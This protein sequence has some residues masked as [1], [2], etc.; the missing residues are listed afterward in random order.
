MAAGLC[1]Q[2]VDEQ[3][4][5]AGHSAEYGDLCHFCHLGELRA[6][7]IDTRFLGSCGRSRSTVLSQD[8]IVSNPTAPPIPG[9]IFDLQ[10]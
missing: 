8:I 9:D 2:A 5:K 6:D 1:I 3:R 4:Q 10:I 7:H